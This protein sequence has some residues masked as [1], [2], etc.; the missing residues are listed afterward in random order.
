[1][2]LYPCKVLRTRERAPIP[3]S[4]A[5]FCLGLIFESLKELRACHIQLM[6]NTIICNLGLVLGGRIK[7]K[8]QE[9]GILF[10]F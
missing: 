8:K 9:G 4:A 2:P 10:N 3:C 7:G 5:V 1:M 6:F